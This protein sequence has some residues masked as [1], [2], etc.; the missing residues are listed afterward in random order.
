MENYAKLQIRPSSRKTYQGFIENYI[1]PTLGDI[2]L[3]KLTAMD[4]QRLCKHLLESG[5]VECAEARNK[6]RGSASRRC[7]TSTR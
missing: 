1:K 6:P 2:P 3:E 7:G 5:R 4:L